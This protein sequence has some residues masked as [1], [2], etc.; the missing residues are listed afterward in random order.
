M[1]QSDYCGVKAGPHVWIGDPQ[2]T[3]GE[4]HFYASSQQSPACVV[5]PGTPEDVGK[6]VRSS[7]S[8]SF[9]LVRRLR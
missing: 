6:I 4:Y 7:L 3:E 5:E 8:A 9:D 1:S 2:Y